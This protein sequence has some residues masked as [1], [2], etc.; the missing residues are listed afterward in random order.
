ME[1]VEWAEPPRAAAARLPDD[2][3]FAPC[4]PIAEK[5]ISWAGFVDAEMMIDV[6]E[7]RLIVRIRNKSEFRLIMMITKERILVQIFN[8]ER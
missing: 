7:D 2:R 5:S 1:R 3:P 6:V 4:R 8:D